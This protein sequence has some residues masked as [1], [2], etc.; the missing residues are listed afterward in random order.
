M[1][2]EGTAAAAAAT[3]P[4][5]LR[6]KLF[7]GF[8]SVSFGVKDNGFSYMLLLYYNQVVGLSAPLVGLALMVALVVD[9]VVDPLI[10][11]VSDNLRTRL[12]RRHP[13]M[14]AAALPVAVSYL[15]LWNPP[16]WGQQQLFG[17]LVVTAVVIRVFISFYEVPSSALSAELTTNYDERTALLSYRYFFGWVGGLTMNFLAFA[18][19]LA[20]DA[21]HK[22]GQLNPVGYSK[23]GLIAS[24]VMFFAILI[25]AAGTQRRAAGLNIPPRRHLPL[26][27]AARELVETVS[28]RSFLFL[29]FSG[30]FGAMASGLVTS[31]NGYFNTFFWE[32]S[33]RQISIFT[34]GVYL[35]AIIALSTAPMLSRRYGKRPVAMSFTALAVAVGIG[36]LLLRLLGLFPPNHT[37]ALVVIIFFTSVISTAFG[38][39]AATMGSSMIA[40]VVEPSE[41][42]TKRRSEG[43]FFAASA[44]VGK[45][46]SGFGILGASMVVALIHLKATTDPSTVPPSVV[47]HLGEVYIPLIIGLQACA[48]ALLLGYKIT[49]AS[50]QETLTSLA[51]E[52]ELSHE[53]A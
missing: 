1:Q 17:Y 36:P 19:L 37:L 32:F 41:L 29:L 48:M 46:V 42:R 16:H 14:Y 38:I 45:A 20:P 8:G 27:Q 15:A 9:A 30:I 6:T 26:R 28:N 33:A 35:S 40:D 5:D 39:V 13:F 52:A 21:T 23:Y 22:V 53:V 10:G 24:V 25:S 34:A 43:V 49:R 12:G 31:L 2:S 44:F 50:H 7:Y 4:L 18:I 11:Q 51:A 47:R 3:A